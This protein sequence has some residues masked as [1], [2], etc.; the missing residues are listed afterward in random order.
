MLVFRSYHQLFTDFVRRQATRWHGKMVLDV[1]CGTGR[2][3]LF[4]AEDNHVTGVDVHNNTTVQHANFTFTQGDAER[5]PFPDAQFDAVVTFDV[6]E[7]VEHDLPFMQEIH[8]VLRPGGK[9]LLGT[10]NRDRLSHQLRRLAGRP[11][12][13]PL[14][15]GTDPLVGPCIHLRE[16]TADNLRTLAA[17]VGFQRLTLTPFWFGLTPLPLGLALAP[18]YLDRY[19]Q[20]W[21]LEGQKGA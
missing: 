15:L 4:F 9:L 16:Y 5:L 20:Y 1:G 3:S 18:R 10:P 19:C 7:H 14:D 11:V 12:V 2:L 21:F 13:Y 17:A 6:I 8:R